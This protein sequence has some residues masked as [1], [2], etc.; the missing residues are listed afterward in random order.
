MSKRMPPI[1]GLLLII[2]TFFFFN[3]NLSVLDVLPDFIGAILIII[4]ILHLADIDD[5]A[6]DASKA[7]TILAL[8][9]VGKTLSLLLLTDADGTVWPL[10]FTFCFGIGEGALFAYGMSKLFS[11]ITY[12]AMRHSCKKL[13]T[14]FSSLVG[15]TVLVAVLKNLL[16]M[17]PELTGLSTDY[18][19]VENIAGTGAQV[20][21]F[22]YKALTILN[23][24]VVTLYGFGW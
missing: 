12:R 8:V 2:G 6:K 22:V 17:L 7:M 13:Y 16:V 19:F 3:P 11:A 20:S 5:R 10:I 1:N 4:G 18:G 14:D 15:L 21:E 23:L 24:V 9:D